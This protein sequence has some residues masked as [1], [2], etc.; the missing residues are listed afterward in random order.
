MFLLFIILT[1]SNYF[2]LCSFTYELYIGYNIYKFGNDNNEIFNC[3]LDQIKLNTVFIDTFMYYG[4]VRALPPN[5]DL[6]D[7]YY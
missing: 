3:E 7:Y 5:Q 1:V 2:H 4:E 6:G